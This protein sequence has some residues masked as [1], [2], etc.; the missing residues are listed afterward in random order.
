MAMSVAAI[1]DDAAIL[2]AMGKALATEG[3]EPHLFR[4]DEVTLARLRGCAPRA[5]VLDVPP[6][7]PEAAMDAL[8]LVRLDDALA[9]TP[10]IVCASGL[11][12]SRSRNHLCDHGFTILPKPVDLLDVIGLLTGLIDQDQAPGAP[13][14]IRRRPLALYKAG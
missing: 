2:A 14:R 4:V 7:W 9:A 1:N 11:R 10:C 13:P 3:Y 6:D 5:I 8:Q 12:L